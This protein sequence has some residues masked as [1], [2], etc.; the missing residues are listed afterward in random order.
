MNVRQ[1]V[2]YGDAD[3]RGRLRQWKVRL[4]QN[5]SRFDSAIHQLR[6]SIR[7][8]GSFGLVGDMVEGA[9][10]TRDKAF[11]KIH[12][13]LGPGVTLEWRRDK[14]G[15]ALAAWSILK[16]RSAV[17]VVVPESAALSEAERASL[18][19]QDCVAV[20]YVL[21]GAVRDLILVADGLWTLE[22]PDHA[23]GRAVERSGF[24][25]PGALIRDAH[26]N[27]LD[28]PATLAPE[29]HRYED[30]G[31]ATFFKAGA[32]C[33]AGYFRT[34]RDASAGGELMAHVRVRT[35]LD[36]NQLHADQIVMAEK[37]RPGERLGDSW[38]LP[39]PLRHLETDRRNRVHVRVLDVGLGNE[40]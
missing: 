32:G 20:N 24:L 3:T 15:H 39:V 8:G 23:L 17:T 36:E 18:L 6:A 1:G 21:V 2:S 30:E 19:Q 31:P 37:G 12:K 28:L 40:P 22:V 11:H 7:A 38:L 26:L 13:M 29:I 27:L 4:A 16:P 34:G 35:W 9:G 33:F 14:R 10:S 25:H 5:Y